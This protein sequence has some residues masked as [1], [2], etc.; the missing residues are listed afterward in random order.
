M[1]RVAVI[2]AN[3]NW[4]SDAEKYLTKFMSDLRVLPIDDPSKID[5][6]VRDITVDAYICDHDPP[7]LDAFRVFEKRIAA[8]DYRPFMIT[9]PDFDEGSLL[10]AF[11]MDVSTCFPRKNAP[12]VDFLSMAKRI[13]VSIEKNRAETDNR[14]NDRRLKALVKLSRMYSHSDKELMYYALEES[15]V[16]TSSDIGYVALYNKETDE[17][18][19]QTWSQRTMAQ[20][21]MVDRPMRYPMQKT[22]LWGQPVRLR[23]SLIVNDYESTNV[24]GKKGTPPGHV[25]LKRLIM[26]PLMHNGEV[27]GTAGVA[28][29]TTDYNESDMNQFILMMD[30]FIGMYM[31]RLA[32]EQRVSLETRM[33]S[34]LKA[35]NF[36]ILLLD[37]RL[38]VQDC[39][40]SATALTSLTIGD[41]LGSVSGTLPEGISEMLA[42]M[43]RSAE[44]GKAE[45]TFSMEG[46]SYRVQI[47]LTRD[48]NGRPYFVTMIE[49][50]TGI[51]DMSEVI[52]R[53]FFKSKLVYDILHMSVTNS[54]NGCLA[55]IGTIP[56]QDVADAVR[57]RLDKIRAEVDLFRIYESI[58][59]TGKEWFDLG[60]MMDLVAIAYRDRLEIVCGFRDVSIYADASLR[61]MFNILAYVSEQS[62]ATRI[63]VGYSISMGKL[64]IIMADDGRGVPEEKK[65]R[66]FL[67]TSNIKSIMLFVAKSVADA[68]GFTISEV[69]DPD[70][71]NRF[72]IVV[73][74]DRYEIGQ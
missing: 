15:I 30:G 36:G 38:T 5:A 41:T 45:H 66:L 48:G 9:A 26:I 16:L 64:K 34:V 23:Q 1:Y 69:G 25:K 2:S 74:A 62:N 56:Q 63:T 8:K 6:S 71:G 32:V 47:S 24:P 54:I 61:S 37:D 42:G 20:T 31:D 59:M 7:K 18:E 19:M 51:A 11:D 53:K 67:D 70:S 35:A 65:A 68:S 40:A 17:L 29:K 43:D 33:S 52:E 27:V 50:V 57:E 10:R 14:L 46:S 28:N 4:L 72:E 44:N 39:N 21:S 12:V 55:A 49:D 58:G 22:G 13:V 60:V 73:P 3:R